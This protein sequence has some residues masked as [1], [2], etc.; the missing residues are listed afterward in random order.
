MA[1]AAGTGG[2]FFAAECDLSKDEDI[3]RTFDWIR[4]HPDLGQVDVCVCNAGDSLCPM[5][6]VILFLRTSKYD[7]ICEPWRATRRLVH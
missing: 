7:K 5:P 4:N 6:I 1:A 2:R 3:R